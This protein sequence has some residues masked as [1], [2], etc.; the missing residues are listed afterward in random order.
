M[1]F[2]NFYSVVCAGPLH[3]LI[4]F[5]HVCGTEF[6]SADA[7]TIP[8]II[9]K[10]L[11][12]PLLS[13]VLANCPTFVFDNVHYTEQLECYNACLANDS[14][15]AKVIESDINILHKII[16]SIE[17]SEKRKQVVSFIDSLQ[18]LVSLEKH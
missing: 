13:A 17:E 3:I 9:E 11:R 5:T 6:A 16:S 12:Y 14:S 7:F 15:F 8:Y 10:G 18:Q 2:R 1:L 4:Y